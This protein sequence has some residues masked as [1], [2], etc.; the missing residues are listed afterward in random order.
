MT[1]LCGRTFARQEAGTFQ[2]SSASP[3]MQRRGPKVASGVHP[4]RRG[5]ARRPHHCPALCRAWSGA[6]HE[7]AAWV[8]GAHEQS[9]CTP[10]GDACACE[11]GSVASTARH[12]PAACP[13][14]PLVRGAESATLSAS[15]GAHLDQ[16]ATGPP[17][18]GGRA[19]ASDRPRRGRGG[20]RCPIFRRGLS[21]GRVRACPGVS[22]RVPALAARMRKTHPVCPAGA[23]GPPSL[24]FF[25][26]D[27]RA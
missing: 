16:G 13:A 22:G 9:R 6:A 17:P 2:S 21:M 5:A 3:R 11:R 23:A 15:A 1:A 8:A 27:V 19:Y 20:Y 26:S 10:A 25:W 7:G 18:G 12:G 4:G 14:A 24:A